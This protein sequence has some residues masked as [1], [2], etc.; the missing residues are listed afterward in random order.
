[1]RHQK[2]KTPPGRSP[3]ARCERRC[4]LGFDGVA[5]LA[6]FAPR[7]NDGQTHLLPDGARKESAK[8]MRLPVGRLKQFL[9]G[10]SARPL[11]QFEDRCGFAAFA[12]V[13]SRAFGRFLLRGG[14]LPGLALGGRDVLATCGSGGL[15]RG[16]S[17]S[18]CGGG[19]HFGLFCGRFHV[20]SLRGDYRVTT[21]IT[22]KA[23]E[24][25]RN[26]SWRMPGDGPLML[27]K[28][29][30]MSSGVLR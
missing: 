15:F 25:K 5:A 6:V 4:K 29:A 19:C 30:Q 17:L 18:R 27:P 23:P 16:L 9:G 20:F 10:G 24:S 12:G 8:G 7:G 3:A 22:L 11:Q 1:M 13:V 2:R 14:L 28:L 21:S 26:Q